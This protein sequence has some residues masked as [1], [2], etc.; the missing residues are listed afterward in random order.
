MFDLFKHR[1]WQTR[2]QIYSKKS[3]FVLLSVSKIVNLTCI[4]AKPI[5][6]INKDEKPS[7][8]VLL[9]HF[10]FYQEILW[11]DMSSDHWTLDE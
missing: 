2:D 3:I 4:D 9:Q 8:P 1:T 10:L 7:Y 5:D 11:F 6:K